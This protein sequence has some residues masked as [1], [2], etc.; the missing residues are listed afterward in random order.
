MI[1]LAANTIQKT[2][3][4]IAFLD[5]DDWLDKTYVETLRGEILKDGEVGV[6]EAVADAY[7]F[8]IRYSSGF[9]AP[10]DAVVKAQRLIMNQ[11]AFFVCV[12]Q[13]W[14]RLMGT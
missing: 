11:V 10:S 4:W 1:V 2:T 6:G 7:L 9:K 3:S 12:L 8:Q 14:L 13:N 5:D